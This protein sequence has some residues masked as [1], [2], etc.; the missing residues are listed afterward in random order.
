MCVLTN[1]VQTSLDRKS[2]ENFEGGGGFGE[3]THELDKNAKMPERK[4]TIIA[5]KAHASVDNIKP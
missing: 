1:A 2:W 3:N 5:C 4:N